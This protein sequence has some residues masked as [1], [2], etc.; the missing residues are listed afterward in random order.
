MY[1]L[2][3][4]IVASLWV[5]GCRDIQLQ[6]APSVRLLECPPPPVPPCQPAKWQGEMLD[7]ATVPPFRDERHYWRITPVRGAATCA[8][9]YAICFLDGTGAIVTRGTRS[10]QALVPARRLGVD[11][12][13]S[14]QPALLLD[15]YRS[16]GALTHGGSTMLAAAVPDECRLAHVVQLS[17]ILSQSSI[18]R[19]A[20]LFEESQV[21]TSHPALS[22]DGSLLVIASDRAGG[23]GG[24]DLWYALRTSDGA[25]DSLRNLGPAVNTPC[26]ELS[27]FVTKDGM[28]LFASNGH[29]SVGGYDLFAVQLRRTSSGIAAGTVENLRPPINTAADELFPST[30]SNYQELLYWSSNR[31]DNNFDL[32]LAQRLERPKAPP[33]AVTAE[34]DELDTFPRARL[35][36]RIQTPDRRPV[37][38]ADVSV[39]ELRRRRLVAQSQTDSS[40]TFEVAVP[41]EQELEITAQSGSGFYDVRRLRIPGSDTLVV[42]NDMTIPDIL[43][44]RINFPHD[45]ARVPYEFVLDTNGQ[46][47][48]R[49]WTEELDRVAANILRYRDRI[50]HIVLVGHTDPNGTD[51]YNLQLGRRRVE[52]VI[53]ELE[54]RG[55]PRSLLKG[56]SAGERQL[57]PPRPGEPT[58]QYYRRCRRVELSKVL[59]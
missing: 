55:V 2:I 48:D 27:P 29:A 43:T 41:T 18:V 47:T 12:L 23:Y 45:Q 24:L 6:Q 39:R 8:E 26:D 50:K 53:E 7:T 49:R 40:G 15:G 33:P 35:R 30:P 32:Y 38:G 3:A 51:A 36:G 1:V 5:F 4:T 37:E 19:S 11:T 28:L 59:Q 9:E 54:K 57:L 13:S 56:L 46:Q 31:R 16:I 20:V 25:W 14:T 22:S 10:V 34:S 17:G 44:L 58:D 52:F 21:W 42:L